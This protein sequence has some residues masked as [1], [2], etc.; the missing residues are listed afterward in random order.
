MNNTSVSQEELD[1]LKKN[2]VRKILSFL[3]SDRADCECCMLVREWGLR[4]SRMKVSDRL[5]M[6]E[7]SEVFRCPKAKGMK[8]YQIFCSE[9]G[10]K[11]GEVSALDN[12]LTDWCDLHYYSESR[13]EKT[14]KFE[15]LPVKIGRKL[16]VK[17]VKVY[18]TVGRWH[19]CLGVQVSVKDG[20][21]G[22]ECACGQDTRDFRIK[23]K[24]TGKELKAKLKEN[25]I[26]RDFGEKNSK[27]VVK[28]VK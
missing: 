1:Y 18:K 12:K 23:N 11:V 21:L 20:K 26:G 5:K 7:R 2:K 4:L 24:L 13:L 6:Q 28:E 14:F 17:R 19:G 3:P 15:E 25:M 27:F 9:C 22:I 10:D 8:Q 16:K